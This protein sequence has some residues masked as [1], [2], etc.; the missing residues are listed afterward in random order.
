M[1]SSTF[2][3]QLCVRFGRCC[4][5]SSSV[6][7][8]GET[9]SRD[10][11]TCAT[12]ESENE[13]PRGPFWG[14]EEVIAREYGDGERRGTSKERVAG[15]GSKGSPQQKHQATTRLRKRRDTYVIRYILLYRHET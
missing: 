3:S 5:D 9:N 1:L 12:S 10:S 6:R 8:K 2:H 13:K 7:R 14:G 15:E 4:R 11:K